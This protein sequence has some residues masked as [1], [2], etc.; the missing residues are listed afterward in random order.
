VRVGRGVF[1]GLAWAL[2]AEVVF[3][4]LVVACV[5][6]A[7]GPHAWM[8]GVPLSLIGAGAALMDRRP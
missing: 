6:L 7:G 5:R 4:A 2:A 3:V 1:V 8:L